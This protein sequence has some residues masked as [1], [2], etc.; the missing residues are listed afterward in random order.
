M[1]TLKQ[2]IIDVQNQEKLTP[3]I[4][5]LMKAIQT[6]QSIMTWDTAPDYLKPREAAK[7][8]RIGRNKIYEYA[9]MQDFPKI[10]IGERNFVIPKEPL[11]RWINGRIMYN[12]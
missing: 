1:E 5:K 7:L 4:V 11:Q 2:R 10:F 3:E 12:R 9:A 6:S 8:M